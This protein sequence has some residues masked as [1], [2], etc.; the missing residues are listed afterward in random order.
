ML[1]F[2]A[3]NVVHGPVELLSLAGVGAADGNPAVGGQHARAVR[4]PRLGERTAS[5]HQH[6]GQGIYDLAVIRHG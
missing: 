6:P 5:P 2:E 4:V 1:L 3:G